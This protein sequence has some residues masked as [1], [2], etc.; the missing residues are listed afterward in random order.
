MDEN[1]KGV[2]AEARL[3][4]SRLIDRESVKLRAQQL[5]QLL[6][7]VRT[8]LDILWGAF[9]FSPEEYFSNQVSITRV[10]LGYIEEQVQ[11]L[12]AIDEQCFRVMVNPP[13]RIDERY[14][15]ITRM[16]ELQ[17]LIAEIRA[18]DLLVKNAFDEQW[19]ELSS[20]WDYLSQAC[21]WLEENSA[22]R[23]V[24]AKLADKA[25]TVHFA[26]ETH[27]F[28]QKI[29]NELE[30]IA[31]ELKGTTETLMGSSSDK[32]KIALA[33]EKLQTWVENS[34]QLSK[35]VAYQHRVT[36]ARKYGLAEVIEKLASGDLSL[37]SSISAVERTYFES[38]LKIMAHDEPDLVRFD[39]ELHSRQVAGFAE[40]DL[41][42][43]KAAS[44]EVVRAHHRQIPSRS[45]GI[46]PVGVLRSEMVKKRGHLPIRQLM[47]KA[48]VA[49]QALKPVMMMSPL[50]VAQFL[51][52]GKQKFDLLVMDEASQIQPVDAIGAIAR[53][54]QV[55]VVGDERQLPPTRFFAKMTE[56]AAND[57][58]DEVSQVAD[59]ESVLGLFVARGLPQRMLRWH[60]RSRHQS[61]IAV[62][63][64]QFYENK[65]FI[66][67]SPYTQ[68]AGMGLQFHHI[69]D[70][71]FESGGKGTNT[72]EAKAVA[73]A[74]MEHA[75]KYPEQSL[76]V[77]TFSVSQRK[78]IQDELELLRRL[79]PI[80]EEFFNAHP[81]EPFF[82]KNLENVQGDERDV[83]MISVGYARNTQGYM[84]MRFGPL[85][86]EGVKEG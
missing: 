60:Y 83:I 45:G 55:V 31:T 69:P 10:S 11:N 68:E 58:D 6:Q 82:V 47:L 48:G 56:S 35:W 67:P 46:G 43:I 49:I 16:I 72:I 44:L 85:G 18:E 23:F 27:L 50:S 3:L 52:P 29:V 53:C 54:K 13:A 62:S 9:G 59:I 76:G 84:A 74:I 20:D 19:K 61:L 22:L 80:L 4:A 51:I 21:S 14:Q 8:P 36:Q 78:A 73:K 28:S 26:R 34:E 25:E 12:I 38:L 70:G 86:S 42:R 24:A 37:D 2:G 71:V 7:Q 57:D 63:N 30:Q 79:N 65:L 39:G 66:V 5:S 33:C 17:K 40:L 81:S 1:T 64:S 75:H 77:A 32:L 15:L 41:K